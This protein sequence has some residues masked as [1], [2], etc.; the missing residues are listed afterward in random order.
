MYELA[1]RVLSDVEKKR[2]GKKI[3]S[4]KSVEGY[5]VPQGKLAK[6]IKR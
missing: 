4:Q 2:I 3:V 5:C 1:G 6:R